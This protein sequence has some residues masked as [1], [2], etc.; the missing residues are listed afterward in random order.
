MSIIPFKNELYLF[1]GMR[2]NSNA[3]YF[4]YKKEKNELFF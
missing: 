3:G 1:I 2:G 4:V